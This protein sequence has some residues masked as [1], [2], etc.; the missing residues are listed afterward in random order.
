MVEIG[1]EC[2]NSRG[3]PGRGNGGRPQQVFTCLSQDIVAHETTYALLDGMH[4]KYL[5]N[6]NAD[7]LAFHEALADIVALLQRLGMP[8]LLRD[9]IA[10]TRGQIRTRQ[11]LLG[12]LAT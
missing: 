6:S 11:S 8:E 5:S 4:R 1:A 9:Q 10:R 3:T 7:V 2:L 12:E